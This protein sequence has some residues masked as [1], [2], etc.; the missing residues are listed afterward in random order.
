[1]DSYILDNEPMLWNSTHRDVHPEPTTYD[2]LLA[3]T[4]AYGTVIRRADP[5]AKIAGPAEWGW[6]AY[7]Y[8]A[9]DA[10]AGVFLRPDRRQHGDVPLIPW[11]LRK[12]REHEQR[13]GTKV[14]D[15]L[16]VHYYP[17]ADGVHSGQTD[18]ATAARRIRSTRSLWDP[19]YKDESWIGE[20]MRVLP[21]LREWIAE[22]YPGLGDLHRRVELRRRQTYERRV[23]H[24]RGA[25][26]L[27]DARCDLGLHLGSVPTTG[28]RHSG[29]FARSE[30]SMGR[31]ALPGLVDTCQG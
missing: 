11:Y 4:I 3:K 24:S 13:T 28:R 23:G 10:A 6:L 22:N 30:T 18:P 2:E 7:H 21:L 20:R 12:L 5:E 15:I 9:K 31:G 14:L 19:T 29:P 17:M 16:D 8:S 25:G 1:M 26:P 27:R